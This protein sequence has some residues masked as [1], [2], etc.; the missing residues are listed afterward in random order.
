M[1]NKKAPDLLL[2]GV[3]RFLLLIFP[4]Q[5]FMLHTVF[6]AYR[7]NFALKNTKVLTSGIDKFFDDFRVKLSY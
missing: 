5:K 3:W 7:V 1:Q 6:E 4:V 2:Y